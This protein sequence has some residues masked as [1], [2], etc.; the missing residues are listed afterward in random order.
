MMKQEAGR[1]R[2]GGVRRVQQYNSECMT[3]D[4]DYSVYTTV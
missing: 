4:Q 3:V 1:R 2:G